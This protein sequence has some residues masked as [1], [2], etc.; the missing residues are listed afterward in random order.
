MKALFVRVAIIVAI[1]QSFASAAVPGVWDPR[2]IGGGGSMFSPSINPAN[3]S[4]FYVACDMSGLYHTTDFGAS[5]ATLPF[6]QIQ[7][8]N[9]AKVCFTSDPLISYCISYSGDMARPVRSL[10]GGASWSVLSGNPDDGE[11]TYSIFADFNHSERVIISYYTAIYFSGNSGSVFTDIHDAADAGAGVVL[12]GVFFAGDT[13]VLGTNDGLIV[14]TDGGAHFA[15]AAKAGI[16]AGQAIFSFAGA[17]QGSAIRFFCLTANAADIYVGIPGSDYGGFMQGVYSLDW[18]SGVWTARMNG[19]T[20]GSDFPMYVAMAWNNVSVAYLGGS[21]GDPL[22]LKTSDG[23][24]SWSHMFNTSG[25]QNIVTGWNGAGGDRGWGYGECLFGIAVAPFNANR[26]V[27]SDMGFVHTTSDGGVT[28]QQSYVSAADQHPAGTI[29]PVGQAYHSIGLE[30]TSCWQVFWSDSTRLFAPFTDIRGVRSTDAGQTW[31]FGYTGLA[32]NTT[33]RVVKNGAGTIYAATSNI[34]DMYQSTRLA[35]AQLD[36]A[37]AEGRI[38]F[39]VNQGA[40]WQNLHLFGHPVFW[41]ALDPGDQN[42]MYASVVHSTQGGVFVTRDLSNGAAATWTR[43]PAPPRTEGHP[44]CI[45]VLNDS[46][47]VCTYSGRRTASGFTASS[48]T[49][50]YSPSL[51]TWTDVSHSGMYYWTKDIVVDPFDASQNTWYVGVFSGWGGPPN[52]LGGLYRTVNR[53][54]SWTRISDLDRV[55]SCTFNPA[56]P[57]EAYVTTETSGLWHSSNITAGAPAFSRVDSYPFRQPERVF[58]NPYRLSEIWVTSFGNGMRVGSTEPQSVLPRPAALTANRRLF[59]HYRAGTITVELP[60]SGPRTGRITVASLDG[61]I[62]CSA[63]A[64]QRGTVSLNAGRLGAGLYLVS[65]GA[66][67]AHAVM[68]VADR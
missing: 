57:A 14:S 37:D 48:G 64:G 66:G 4:E 35:D 7:G 40:V 54:Q 25:N 13:I 30:N 15:V 17:K 38:L 61:R 3:D 23:G 20:A 16:S 27:V 42:I 39:S 58:F 49:F 22:V 5:Y 18:P 46:T 60:V 52:G 34:H 55:T 32:A 6:Y 8:A 63:P 9:N 12:G 51:N 1:L 19:I 11:V 26:V 43:L 68:A 29:I 56:D 31:S 33:Y 2:G 24:A 65:A 67:G 50:A 10:D 53:G 41:I 28:W 47:V 45:V 59:A 21:T 36:A 44:A 62:I